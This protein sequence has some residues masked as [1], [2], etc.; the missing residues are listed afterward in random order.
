M[1]GVF[2]GNIKDYFWNEKIFDS[3]NFLIPQTMQ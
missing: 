3:F 2:I 1:S